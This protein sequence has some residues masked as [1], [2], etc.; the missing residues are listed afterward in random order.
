MIRKGV[1]VLVLYLTSLKLFLLG[2]GCL[3]EKEV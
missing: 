3:L 1:K 2:Q